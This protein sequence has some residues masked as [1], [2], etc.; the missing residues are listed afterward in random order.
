MQVKDDD[1]DVSH[2]TEED[3]IKAHGALSQQIEDLEKQLKEEQDKVASMQTDSDAATTIGDLETQLAA[4]EL[5]IATLQGTNSDLVTQLQAANNATNAA[6][7]AKNAETE[8]VIA[9][10]AALT[11]AE[12]TAAAWEEKFKKLKT[13][14]EHAHG[15]HNAVRL[16]STFFWS[17]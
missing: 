8:K 2:M 7:D 10:E 9:A 14:T 6:Q 13:Q 12:A 15:H 4:K 1:D 11:A 3:L 16:L 17:V 5:E